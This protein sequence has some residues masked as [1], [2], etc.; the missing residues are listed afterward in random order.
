M[1]LENKKQT[2]NEHKVSLDKHT[3][4]KPRILKDAPE[5]RG[6]IGQEIDTEKND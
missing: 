2:I 6:R 3:K 4:N 1:S 5:P